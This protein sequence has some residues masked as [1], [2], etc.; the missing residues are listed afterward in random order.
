MDQQKPSRK[1]KAKTPSKKASVAPLTSKKDEDLDPLSKAERINIEQVFAQALSKY[2]DELLSKTK[3]HNKDLSHLSNIVEEYLSCFALIG[4]S[5]EGDK[6][7]VFNAHNAKD[8]AALVDHLRS[9]F[10]DIANN[11]P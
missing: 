8:E 7:C 1:K 4:Y 2:K 11:R 9:T 5:I 3:Q 10:I 6:V